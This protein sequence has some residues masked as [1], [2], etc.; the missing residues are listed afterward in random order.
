[1]LHKRSRCLIHCV[2][3]A[4]AGY[5]EW[6]KWPLERQIL[7]AREAVQSISGIEESRLSR[8]VLGHSIEEVDLPAV[9]VS[10]GIYLKIHL[11][12]GHP[13]WI[14][15]GDPGH[16]HVVAGPCA[17]G[18]EHFD[19][20]FALP[21]FPAEAGAPIPTIA[22]KREF[23]LQ[24]VAGT[25]RIEYRKD[26]ART[27]NML[28]GKSRLRLRN[29][30]SPNRSPYAVFNVLGYERV[31]LDDACKSEPVLAELY[32]GASH[33]MAIHLG[34]LQEYWDMT[35]HESFSGKDRS[36]CLGADESLIKQQFKAAKCGRIEGFAGTVW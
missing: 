10:F 20:C 14:A 4:K 3:A 32:K 13:T 27:A 30:Y 36:M 15:Y 25:K 28:K 6:S 23:F 11:D 26:D 7:R 2:V 8:Y 22:I 17:S 16:K 18:A 12:V 34:Q 24:C 33:V 9:A 31:R 29:G 5:G 21:R 1:M 19:L 35:A